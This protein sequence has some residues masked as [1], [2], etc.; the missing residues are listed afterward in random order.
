MISK[1]ELKQMY[2]YVGIV[3]YQDQLVRIF[4]TKSANSEYV[5]YYDNNGA[6]SLMGAED[7]KILTENLNPNID[8]IY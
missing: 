3:Y 8:K 6:L 7:S 1:E 5:F 4:K 2:F